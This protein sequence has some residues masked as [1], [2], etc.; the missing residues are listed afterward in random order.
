MASGG[1]IF[2]VD[3]QSLAEAFPERWWVPSA[4]L[5]RTIV[6]GRTLVKVLALEAGEDGGAGLNAA[7]AIWVVVGQ[8]DEHT[9]T[10]TI[11][12]SRI[13]H[14]GYRDGDRITV[15]LDRVFDVVALDDDG[16]PQLN[17]QRARFAI[18]KRVLVGV[19]ILN[20]GDEVVEQRQ[21]AGTIV[22]VD[23]I[24]GIELARGDGSSYWLPPDGR[25]LEEAS[26]GEY[27]L[28]STGEVVLNPDYL[29][30]W[31]ITHGDSPMLRDTG[32]R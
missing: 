28:R 10:G 20:D 7:A 3:A 18:G 14:P 17:E 1:T 16:R 11:S 25:S 4:D 22:S 9:L 2:L 21:F 24:E 29:S 19:S 5:L 30:T 15:P 6:P 32:Y 13:Q 27:R 26:P 23:P 12:S 8:R 31:T